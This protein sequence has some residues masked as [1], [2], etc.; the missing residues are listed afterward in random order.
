MTLSG[1]AGLSARKGSKR[2]D[3]RRSGRKSWV[4]SD[5]DQACHAHCLPGNLDA[6]RV[7]SRVGQR[8]GRLLVRLN[9]LR[10]VTEDVAWTSSELLDV[11]CP[12][13]LERGDSHFGFEHIV[14]A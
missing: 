12:A 3:G 8:N 1:S 9:E 7:H 10:E 14:L 4:G 2:T 11:A 13:A 5:N 6:E